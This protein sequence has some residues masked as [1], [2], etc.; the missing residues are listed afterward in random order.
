M[1]RV[2]QLTACDLASSYAI[3]R[4][5]VGEPSATVAARFL[6]EQVVPAFR[7]APR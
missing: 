3:A 7:R 6:R 1:G 2:W 5:F 4:V